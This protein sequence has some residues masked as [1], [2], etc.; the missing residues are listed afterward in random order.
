MPRAL[1]KIRLMQGGGCK[2]DENYKCPVRL[3]KCG[4]S[5]K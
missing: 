2:K 1:A 4:Y 5:A 3:M